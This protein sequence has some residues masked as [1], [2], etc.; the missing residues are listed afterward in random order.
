MSLR[1]GR[2]MMDLAVWVSRAL[3]L[4]F[5][6]I[7]V[8]AAFITWRAHRA[9]RR[10]AEE[11]AINPFERTPVKRD[12]D[13]PRRALRFGA[14]VIALLVVGQG[15]VILNNMGRPP[16]WFAAMAGSSSSSSAQFEP[17]CPAEMAIDPDICAAWQ[18]RWVASCTPGPDICPFDRDLIEA[19]AKQFEYDNCGRSADPARCLYTKLRDMAC[20]H[21]P[22]PLGCSRR[23]EREDA[24]HSAASQ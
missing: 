5:V 6:A 16:E 13:E 15:F 3:F 20:S 8:L 19:R 17:D 12:R 21:A 23:A 18:K 4:A 14:V 1:E 24:S 9:L 22:D 10:E 2:P 11:A 7:P